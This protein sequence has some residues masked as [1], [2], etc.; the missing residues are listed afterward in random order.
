VR[1]Y[2]DKSRNELRYIDVTLSTWLIR[3]DKEWMIEN[4]PNIKSNYKPV[5]W[6]KRDE[7]ILPKVKRVVEEIKEGKSERIC[8]TTVGSKLGISGWLSKRRDKLPMTKDYIETV[9]ESISEFQVRKIEYAIDELERRGKKI[10]YWSLLEMAGVKSRYLDEIRDKIGPI[11]II[12][13]YAKELLY[14]EEK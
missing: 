14:L 6:S 10:T 2:T 13:G 8:W 9:E 1:Q 7:E 5:D 12:K 3:H 11:L 4:S